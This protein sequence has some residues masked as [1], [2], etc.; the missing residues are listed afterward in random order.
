MQEICSTQQCTNNT[1]LSS[2]QTHRR[3]SVS[4]LLS[5]YAE[6]KVTVSSP[7][8]DYYARGEG[9]TTVTCRTI[10]TGCSMPELYSAATLVMAQHHIKTNLRG[11]QSQAE[12]CD[13]QKPLFEGPL[14]HYNRLTYPCPPP[15]SMPP[16]R[17]NSLR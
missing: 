3:N 11:L 2:R 4:D 12:C 9:S 1:T 17:H 10:R 16:P 13:E 15:L 5:K 6:Q 8:G 14:S 7:R